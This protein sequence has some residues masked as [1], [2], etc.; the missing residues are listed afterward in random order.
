VTHKMTPSER[1]EAPLK[2]EETA[3]PAKGSSEATRRR[4][5]LSYVLILTGVALMTVVITTLLLYR[6]ARTQQGECL[7]D[8][9][10]R[11]V[12]LIESVARF[13]A[14]HS[15]DAHPEGARAATL[16]QII[17]ANSNATGFG[18]T[19]EF[20][21]AERLGEE[22]VFLLRHRSGDRDAPA[23]IAWE[24]RRA[25]PMRRA[26]SGQTGT[27]LALDYRGTTVLAAFAP[28]EGLGVGLV[29]KVD[30]SEIRYPFIV[31]GVVSCIITL[32]GVIA[33]TAI[34]HRITGTLLVRLFGSEELLRK[35]SAAVDQSP[36]GI[37]ILDTSG[38]VEYV[39]DHFLVTAGCTAQEIIGH[40]LRTE[41]STILCSDGCRPP[42]GAIAS[43]MVWRGET[44]NVNPDG[45][46]RWQTVVIVPIRGAT[47]STANFL[48]TL[49]D[50][51]ERKVAEERRREAEAQRNEAQELSGQVLQCAADPII[52]I[53]ARGTVL[54]AS[55]SV[56]SVFQ[57][58]VDE[59]VGENISVLMP[60]PHR[61][62]HNEYL[63]THLSTGKSE[64]LGRVIQFDG[65]RKDG[66][67]FPVELRASRVASASNPLFVGILRDLSVRLQL[68]RD[69]ESARRLESIGQLAAGIAHE[70]NTPTQY[71]GD[72][73]LFLEQS[74]GD[75]APL[76]Q[77]ADLLAE[78]VRGGT[79]ST[80]LADELK[81]AL[82][83][84]DFDF[85]REEI[86]RAIEQ[87]L[88]GIDRVRKIVQ[89]MKEFSHPGSE[90]MT[91][92]DINR[93]IES[94]ITV[95]SNEWKYVAE[96]E[97]DFD[98][99]LPAISCLPGAVNQVVL[100]MIVN[101]AHAIA[102]VVDRGEKGKGTITIR[103]RQSGEHV[104]ISISDTGT[105][106][107]EGTRDRVFDPFFTT[108]EVGKGTGQGLSIAHGVVV[109]KHGGTL[110]F[111]TQVGTGT[112]FVIRLPIER[113]A[114]GGA[115]A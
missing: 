76:L 36:A 99:A 107:P 16:S 4:I 84:A 104:E 114:T 51:T 74:F 14:Q 39:N 110:D 102:D 18:K 71:V 103:T 90:G 42:W 11:Q 24:D 65:Q 34:V 111:E 55:A 59:L 52:V 85:L 22:I 48:I 78:A 81:A 87:S 28:V 53:D 9:V 67:T 94:T 83:E 77:K 6:S 26:L 46:Q 25:E 68:E 3:R 62:R 86:P 89:S 17:D 49:E 63:R 109:K 100:N 44:L 80:E 21:M 45:E 32:L 61:S 91:S 92:H 1:A 41:Q 50:V 106:I 96:V 27:C 69:L 79:A 43:G 31:A 105:G 113:Q 20:A 73:T 23:P 58:T 12:S 7:S 29:S 37:V 30:L 57:W 98:P 72:N 8:A 64:A 47:G 38:T 93:A 10:R 40:D 70:I 115:T 101:A 60:E 75:V 112:T 108:K 15:D 97:T 2:G 88:S 66:T 54:S 13:D 35:L 56:H 5:L 95:A 19:G 33:G 82:E